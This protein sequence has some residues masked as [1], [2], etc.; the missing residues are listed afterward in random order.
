[1][2]RKWS[3]LTAVTALVAIAVRENW[4]V[5]GGV[6]RWCRSSLLPVVGSVRVRFRLVELEVS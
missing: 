1:M 6:L 4:R 2:V 5:G 3:K